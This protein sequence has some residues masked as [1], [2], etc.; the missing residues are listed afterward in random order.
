MPAKVESLIG[1]EFIITREYAAPQ[2]LVWRACTES[3]HLAQWW[4][5]RG[6][7]APVCEWDAKP[8]NKIYVVMRAPDGTRYPM[9]G[10][11]LEV[12]PPER[13]VTVTGALDEAGNLMFEFHHTLTLFERNGRT[14][15]TMHSRLTKLIAPDADRYV[16]GFEAGMT[17]SLER[18]TEVVDKI[19]LTADLKQPVE[20]K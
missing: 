19:C 13:L 6:F 2:E 10:E 3:Q 7:T 18:L 20:T 12:V 15:L 8:G 11:F 4:G 17:Q 14:K 16:G 1:K 5:P 9:G